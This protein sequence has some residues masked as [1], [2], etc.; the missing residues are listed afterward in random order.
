[1]GS[2]RS[3]KRCCFAEAEGL[4]IRLVESIV[5]LNYIIYLWNRCFDCWGRPTCLA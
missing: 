2:V 3:G 5:L 1:M 4:G